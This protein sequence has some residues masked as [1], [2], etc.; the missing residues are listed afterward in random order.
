MLALEQLGDFTEGGAT[1]GP[2][3]SESSPYRYNLWR[4][5]TEA[6][7]KQARRVGF[8]MLNPS[9][10]TDIQDDPTIRRCMGYA[11]AWGFDVLEVA[12]IFALRATDPR[13]IYRHGSP[14]GPGNDSH[15]VE[16][17]RRV[18]FVV[19]AW[20]KHGAFLARGL[21]A[22]RHLESSGADLRVLRLNKDGC[23]THP[24]YLPASLQPVKWEAA[25]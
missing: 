21:N 1:F 15:L 4:R 13:E 7:L 9:T 10:A 19:C 20:G 14:I 8:V 2:G 22:R 6:P 5:L 11:R 3:G 12:N 16:L 24:L 17:A 23:P 25:R 18:G